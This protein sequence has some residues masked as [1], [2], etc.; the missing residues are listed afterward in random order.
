MIS[1]AAQRKGVSFLG[2]D[3]VLDGLPRVRLWQPE[4]MWKLALH[5]VFMHTTFLH[6][7]SLLSAMRLSWAV[8]PCDVPLVKM[9][10]RCDPV[11]SLKRWLPHR[12]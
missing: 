8:Q 12:C 5:L 6:D 11:V 10:T 4:W 3:L 1:C 7:N 2:L 9:P